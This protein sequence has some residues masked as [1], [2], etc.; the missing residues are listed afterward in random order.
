MTIF[1]SFL[2]TITLLFLYSCSGGRQLSAKSFIQHLND[3]KAIVKE[4]DKY[5][6]N[7]IRQTSA[8]FLGCPIQKVN[9]QLCIYAEGM[10][11]VT[12]IWLGEGCGKTTFCFEYPSDLSAQDHGPC[13]PTPSEYDVERLCSELSEWAKKDSDVKP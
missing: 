10:R 12:S 6:Y 4:A 11:G 8:R 13:N 5:L 7:Y 1:K 9:A 2:A 3:E